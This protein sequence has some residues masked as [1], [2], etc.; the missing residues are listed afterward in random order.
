MRE[1]NKSFKDQLATNSLSANETIEELR[2]EIEKLK[3]QNKS[4]VDEQ[5]EKNNKLFWEVEEL[6]KKMNILTNENEQLKGQINTSIQ[7]INQV[8]S[9]IKST[10][11]ISEFENLRTEITQL[12]QENSAAQEENKKIAKEYNDHIERLKQDLY[13][14][15]EQNERLRLEL[16]ASV[17]SEVEQLKLQIDQ[18]ASSNKKFETELSELKQQNEALRNQ[19][20][21]SN[22][23][24]ESLKKT[25]E[26]INSAIEATKAE[27][28]STK[29]VVADLGVAVD[30][31]RHQHDQVIRQVKDVE[32]TVQS[33][34]EELKQQQNMAQVTPVTTNN[35]ELELKFN[36][37]QNTVDEIK[38][39]TDRAMAFMDAEQQNIESNRTS[40]QELRTALTDLT[41][42]QKKSEELAL[43]KFANLETRASLDRQAWE[44]FKSA[45]DKQLQG[46]DYKALIDTLSHRVDTVQ[47]SFGKFEA[48]FKPNVLALIDAHQALTSVNEAC[49]KLNS[50]YDKLDDTVRHV[51]KSVDANNVSLDNFTK[52]LK[53]VESSKLPVAK[54]DEFVATDWNSHVKSL[55]EL[56]TLVKSLCETVKNSV[57]FGSDSP[58]D[59]TREIK[60]EE[61]FNLTAKKSTTLVQSIRTNSNNG[62]HNQH[63]RAGQM[64]RMSKVF[65]KF[66][67]G[68]GVGL[69][70]GLMSQLILVDKSASAQE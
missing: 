33:L 55:G 20:E 12:K 41:E 63:N 3:Q 48:D 49:Q 38:E 6:H 21:A 64:D 68:T 19:I 61:E 59:Q 5:Q 25:S 60:Y 52:Q 39:K 66:L 34:R 15:H 10:D 58:H 36:A 7:Q 2:N 11:Q 67:A 30:S 4:A 31:S 56:Q 57:T 8:V 44:E 35:E 43:A 13:S 26:A 23:E 50:K 46:L 51:S 54:F 1:E 17:K 62:P 22:S 24:I 53:S 42:K 69:A 65:N 37:L 9:Q 47:E 70:A 32:A 14:K 18:S 27:L 45:T 29:S 28:V 16:E 40:L